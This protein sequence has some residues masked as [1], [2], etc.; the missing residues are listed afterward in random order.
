M[1]KK[2]LISLGI[3]VIIALVVFGVSYLISLRKASFVLHDDITRA[4]I[5]RKDKQKVKDISSD[6]SMFLRKGTYYI[7]PEG[8]NFSKDPINF[9]VNNKDVTVEVNPSYTNEYLSE[10]L[11]DEQP[12]IMTAITEKYPS[13]ITGYTLNR[14]TLYK[15]GEWFGG[16]LQPKVTDPRDQR[17][18]YR[19][20]LHKNGDEWEVVRRPEYILTSSRYKEVPIDVLRAV[21]LIV[22]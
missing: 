22:G 15:K 10:L 12:A 9:T 5:Y 20:V 8:E 1:K 18:P 6:S 14:G 17:D 11:K 13:L 3:L 4:T 19:I 7:I 16:L 2:I 21:N